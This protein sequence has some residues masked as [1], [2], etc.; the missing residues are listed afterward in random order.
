M[1]YLQIKQVRLYII[2]NVQYACLRVATLVCY[3]V[4]MTPSVV[5][6]C[7]VYEMQNWL[8]TED[9]LCAEARLMMSKESNKNNT[10]L[11]NYAVLFLSWL[12]IH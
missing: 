9:V 8:P 12:Q 2:P 10:L 4:A 7:N 6:A 3:R 5:Y 11:I 1:Y